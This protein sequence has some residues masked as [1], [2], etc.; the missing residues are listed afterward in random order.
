VF[1]RAGGSWGSPQPLAGGFGDFGISVAVS[2]E[3]AVVGCRNQSVGGNFGQG[4]TFVYMKANGVWGVTQ[5]LTASDGVA[6]DRFGNA[7]DI[8]GDTIIVGSPFNQV[9]NNAEQ[10]SAYIFAPNL[11]PTITA[12]PVTVQQGRTLTGASI[13]T[14]SDNETP[15][16]AL[17]VAVISGG[18]ATGILLTNM[19]NSGGAITANVVANCAATSG[20]VRLQVTDAG[21]L[22]ATAD[23]QVNVTSNDPPVINC[24]ANVVKP[25][26]PTKC[27][28]VVTFTATASDD[29][30]GAIT[31][32]C[33]PPSGSTFSKG[34]TTVTCTAADTSSQSTSC[35]FTVT[36][37]DTE[38]PA[39]QCPANLTVVAARPGDATTIVTYAPPAATDN[40]AIQSVICTPP[41]GS[42]LPLGVTTVTCT[43]TDTSG[44]RAGCSFTVTVFDVCLQDDS[45]PNTA[46]VWNSLTG[47]Y[48]FCCTGL[49]YTGRGTVARVG[50]IFTLT[51]NS[52]DRRL[53]A[54]VDALQN[55]GT[56]TLQVPAGVTRCTIL[57][58]DLRNNTCQC[59]LAAAGP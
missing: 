49:T 26:D 36:V 56:A 32:L 10:G 46:I 14:V 27:S 25:T 59:A 33:A 2:G 43:A 57:D 47:D 58:R 16:G 9:G 45:S 17:T 44:N 38:R 3:T 23:L 7:V 11:P 8:S 19:A 24:P 48:R 20:T 4:A 30:D 15:A 35:S 1:E 5:M 52:T 42:A 13:A 28:A 34:T 39:I 21:G 22:T 50:S 29:C 41:S 55:R 40:C 51:H 18:S 31:P 12:S 53:V 54:S 6:N 37:N